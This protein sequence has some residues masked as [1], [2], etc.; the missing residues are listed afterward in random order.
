M[1]RQAMPELKPALPHHVGV[2]IDAAD[3]ETH[4]RL[5]G[6]PGAWEATV[7]GLVACAKELLDS[8]IRLSV[9]SVLLP[10]K[11]AYLDG[12]PKLLRLLGLREW[13]VIHICVLA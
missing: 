8:G 7:Y 13:I 5:R 11:R 4:D 2:S 3:P 6:V 10:R 12:M 9:L 1:L